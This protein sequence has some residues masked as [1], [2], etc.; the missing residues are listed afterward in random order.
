MFDSDA[1][2][3]ALT[4]PSLRYRGR[5]YVGRTLSINEWVPLEAPLR[6]CQS[7]EGT[8]LDAY[9]VISLF[10][11]VAFRRPWYYFDWARV[12]R[13]PVHKII[14]R[15]PPV[16]LKELTRDFLQSQAEAMGIVPATER[17]DTERTDD[18]P[19]NTSSDDLSDS[20]EPT[21][22]TGTDGPPP[23]E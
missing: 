12:W 10:C 2:I 16:V 8:L 20:T 3:E 1:H 13:T 9:E 4:P 6:R 7:G 22:S 17:D 23:M 14:F 11:R 5:V 15:L 19:P 21:I 18:S